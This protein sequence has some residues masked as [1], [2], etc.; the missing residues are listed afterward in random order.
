MFPRPPGTADSIKEPPVKLEKHFMGIDHKTKHVW[1]KEEMSY[2]FIPATQIT[3][4]KIVI[5]SNDSFNIYARLNL[6][7]RFEY[8]LI[9]N[10]KTLAAAKK[11]AEDFVKLIQKKDPEVEEIKQK[12]EPETDALE[13]LK[14]LASEIEIKPTV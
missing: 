5:A 7:D 4:V 8:K 10:K 2:L 13:A 6:F 12:K 11:L 1:W 3:E 14:A 9:D